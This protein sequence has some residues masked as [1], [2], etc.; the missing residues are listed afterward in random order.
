[1]K[2]THRDSVLYCSVIYSSPH[3]HTQQSTCLIASPYL[4]IQVNAP[5]NAPATQSIRP[6]FNPSFFPA[7]QAVSRAILTKEKGL[8][9]DE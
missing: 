5:L 6:S 8:C 9:E 7:S 3:M 2:D 4:P 1:M